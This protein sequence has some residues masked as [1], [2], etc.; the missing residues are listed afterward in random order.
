VVQLHG[1]ESEHYIAT[2][3]AELPVQCQIWKAIGIE[4]E[5]D[6]KEID[7]RYQHVDRLLLDTKVGAQSGGTGQTFDWRWLSQICENTRI[8]LA[9][10]ISPDNANQARLS[11]AQIIDV[12]SGIESQKGVKDPAK[13]DALF[14]AIREY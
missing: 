6:L 9:G 11:N 13:L 14:D 4:N 1:D 3:K 5:D 2:L 10:G 12:N 8:A 7:S